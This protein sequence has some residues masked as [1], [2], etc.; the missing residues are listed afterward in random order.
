MRKNIIK[1]TFSDDVDSEVNQADDTF[2][3]QILCNF[4]LG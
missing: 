3:S 4:M 1:K 2:R